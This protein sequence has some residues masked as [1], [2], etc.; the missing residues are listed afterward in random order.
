MYVEKLN[1]KGRIVK[2]GNGNRYLYGTCPVNLTRRRDLFK[3]YQTLI[4][5]FTFYPSFQHSHRCPRN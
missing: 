3:D 4:P 2:D 5:D 1:T